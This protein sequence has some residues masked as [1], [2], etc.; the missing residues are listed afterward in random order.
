MNTLIVTPTFNESENIAFLLGELI[1]HAPTVHI[2]V[3][4]DNSPDGTAQI[5]RRLQEENKQIHLLMRQNREGLAAAYTEGLIWGLKKGYSQIIQMDADLSH[6][7]A[8]IPLF[9]ESLEDHSL[10]LGCRYIAGGGVSGW[11]WF[12]KA[13]SWCGNLYARTV[14]GLP[15]RDLT[16]GFMG[17]RSELLQ[18]I[19]LGSATSKGYAYLIELKFR[20]FLCKA[21]AKEIP[22]IFNDRTRG[23]SKMSTSIFSEAAKMVLW[24]RWNRSQIKNKMSNQTSS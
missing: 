1:K 6:P 16:G 18:V 22:F 10:V 3:V 5:V 23:K 19:D 15:F 13:I 7:P 11:P 12:R 24:L 20:A 9:L 8:L 14:L 17:W 4:D 2:L 21:K